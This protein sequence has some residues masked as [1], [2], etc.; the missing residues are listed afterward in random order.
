MAVLK[1]S[2]PPLKSKV[3]FE[4]SSLSRLFPM[5]DEFKQRPLSQ[6]NDPVSEAKLN[7]LEPNFE[8]NRRA[9]MSV[10]GFINLRSS[11]VSD[12]HEAVGVKIHSSEFIS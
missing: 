4:K 8:V 3:N 11:R 1:L 10:D 5:K 7:N 6:T 9:R 2:Q 12:E